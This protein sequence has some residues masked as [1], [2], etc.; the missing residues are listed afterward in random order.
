MRRRIA[1]WQTQWFRLFLLSVLAGRLTGWPS[2]VDLL[3]MLVPLVLAFVRPPRRHRDP[4]VLAAP[5]R[6]RWVA[7]NSP[8]SKVPSHGVHA[9]GQ[10]YAIDVLRPRPSGPKA[11]AGWGLRTRRPEQ[12]SS[13]GEPVLAVGDGTVVVATGSQ[14]D[15]RARDTWPA[16]LLMLTVEGMV[17]EL[18]GVRGVLGNHLVVDHGGGVFAVYAHLRRGSLLVGAGDRVRAG[19]RLAEVGNTGNTSEPHLHFQLMDRPHP[20]AAA[21]VPWRWAGIDARAGDLDPTWT[22]G[23]PDKPVR[24]G[25]ARRRAVQGVPADG[26]IFTAQQARVTRGATGGPPAR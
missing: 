9:Y 23:D 4:V 10:T 17:R 16:L 8:G 13:F 18:R 26:Q 25:R 20:A 3:V 1:R 21:G 15:H 14:R 24:P 6:G 5:V 22:T 2:T 12:Y 7:L 11:V 19:R